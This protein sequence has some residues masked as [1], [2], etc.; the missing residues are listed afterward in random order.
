MQLTKRIFALSLALCLIVSL[1]GCGS[2]ADKDALHARFTVLY[3]TDFL[4]DYLSDP[5]GYAAEIASFGVDDFAKTFADADAFHCYNAEIAVGNDNDFGVSILSLQVDKNDVGKGG[6]WF[7]TLGDGASLT[8]TTTGTGSALSVSTTG[9]HAGGVV[10]MMGEGATLTLKSANNT[11]VTEVTTSYA[12]GYAGGIVSA[13]IDGVR[14][15][16]AL[17]EQMNREEVWD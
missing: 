1:T 15:A 14:T 10:G 9:G 5:E 2:K 4:Q 17:V 8:V 6:V 16:K 3:R 12:T 11:R 7:S 13:A